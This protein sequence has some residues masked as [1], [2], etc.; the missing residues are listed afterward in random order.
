MKIK[1]GIIN[2]NEIFV[3]CEKGADLL[4]NSS[5]GIPS[6][7]TNNSPVSVYPITSFGSDFLYNINDNNIETFE[8]LKDLFNY[9]FF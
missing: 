5:F 2:M 3:C 9:N 6:N 7:I 8:K 1:A 4:L